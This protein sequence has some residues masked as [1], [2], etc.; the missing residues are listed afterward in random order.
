M[1]DEE[2][3]TGKKELFDSWKFIFIVSKELSLVLSPHPSVLG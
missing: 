3:K 2:N 1:R